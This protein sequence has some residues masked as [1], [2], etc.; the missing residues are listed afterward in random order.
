MGWSIRRYV[1]SDEADTL[2]FRPVA[3]RRLCPTSGRRWGWSGNELG[4]GNEGMVKV[5]CW[6][7]PAA[8]QAIEDVARL[9]TGR[10]GSGRDRSRFGHWQ[11]GTDAPP[12]LI[13]SRQCGRVPSLRWGFVG[14]GGGD[15]DSSSS[16]SHPTNERRFS[17]VYARPLRKGSWPRQVRKGPAKDVPPA[18]RFSPS[19]G[20]C[21]RRD[22][23]RLRPPA[24]MPGG[25]LST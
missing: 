14:S 22:P 20:F 2:W 13:W 3:C 21:G 5:D 15:S 6:P 19:E 18:L 17:R 12:T 16:S 25:D 4:I 24:R 7:V 11:S 1:G 23:H 8:E 9:F 10:G